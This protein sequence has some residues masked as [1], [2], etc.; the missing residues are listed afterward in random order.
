MQC[1]IGSLFV[2]WVRL[3][4]ICAVMGYSKQGAESKENTALSHGSRTK[5]DGHS[6]TDCVMHVGG[7]DIPR[8]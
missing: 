1:E 3:P 8:L 7:I 4:G 2:Q 6:D 5:D